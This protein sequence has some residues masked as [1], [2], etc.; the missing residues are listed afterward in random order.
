MY[1][2]DIQQADTILG[3]HVVTD[4]GNR[5]EM[6]NLDR[7]MPLLTKGKLHLYGKAEAKEKRKMGHIN[8]LGDIESSLKAINLTNIWAGSEL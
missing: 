6:S 2:T 5:N 3:D 8:M 7:Y 1:A 4:H